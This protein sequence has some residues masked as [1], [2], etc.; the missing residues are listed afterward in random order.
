MRYLKLSQN[1]RMITFCGRLSHWAQDEQHGRH[2]VGGKAELG[3]E[4]QVGI[5]I[6]EVCR[7]LCDGFF[8]VVEIEC[9][10]HCHHRADLPVCCVSFLFLLYISYFA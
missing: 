2:R 1:S 9:I 7:L 3:G 10:F 4:D 5:G 8:W 6:R